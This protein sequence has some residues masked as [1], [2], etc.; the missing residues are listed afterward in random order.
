V[1]VRRQPEPT[2]VTA[3]GVPDWVH[4]TYANI[5]RAFIDR[6][7]PDEVPPLPDYLQVDTTRPGMPR[8]TAAELE[9][10]ARYHAARNAHRAAVQAWCDERGLDYNR[11]VRG[12]RAPLSAEAAAGLTGAPEDAR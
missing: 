5:S 3:D 11:T 8:R 1:A 2:A 6:W 12:R 9:R 7:C 4:P 10:S